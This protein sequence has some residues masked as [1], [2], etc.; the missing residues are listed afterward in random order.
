[1][2]CVAPRCMHVYVRSV[3][4][5][6]CSVSH[7]AWALAVWCVSLVGIELLTTVSVT[8]T[9]K[10]QTR[11]VVSL[12]VVSL[13]SDFRGL[14]GRVRCVCQRVSR[15]R[16]VMWYEDYFF[17]THIYILTSILDS[18]NIVQPILEDT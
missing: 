6:T 7:G 14:S 13:T 18:H 11:V 10:H 2:P 5:V 8:E 15:R 12:S 3:S 9:H 1:M 4:H 17:C 16:H